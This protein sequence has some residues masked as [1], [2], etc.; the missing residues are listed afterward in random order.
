MVAELIAQ[1][2]IELKHRVNGSITYHDSCFLGRYNDLYQEPRDIIDAIEGL[3][4]KEPELSKSTGY[5]CGAG[6]GR[7]WLEEGKEKVNYHR[8]SVSLTALAAI[9]SA[10][11]AP[12]SNTMLTDG[13]K[14][15][16]RDE[17]VAVK[18]LL[19]LVVEAKDGPKKKPAAGD[20]ATEE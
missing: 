5:C 19:E 9:S 7:M 11:A 12:T 20:T 14:G 2:Q 1:K 18:D 16:D 8:F 4:L 13:S 6:G 15:V 17:D 10:Q 3:T